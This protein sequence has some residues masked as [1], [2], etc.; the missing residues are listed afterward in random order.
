MQQTGKEEEKGKGERAQYV[1][2][3]ANA[4]EIELRYRQRGRGR[5]REGGT[6][7]LAAIG[8]QKKRN[9]FLRSDLFSRRMRDA[10]NSAHNNNNRV[11]ARP[12]QRREFL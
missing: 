4:S 10:L 2:Y 11:F 3:A 5:G 12:K 7:A 1:E 8:L 9:S 6:A